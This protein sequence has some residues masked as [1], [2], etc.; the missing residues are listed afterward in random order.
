MCLMLAN[1]MGIIG[2]G[3][4]NASLKDFA[5]AIKDTGLKQ[6]GDAVSGLNPDIMDWRHG[7]VSILLAESLMKML[8]NLSASL[9]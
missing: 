3:M 6:L 9:T 1:I 8:V 5:G 4:L 7:Y 2:N